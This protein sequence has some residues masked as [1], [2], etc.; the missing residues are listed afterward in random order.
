[1]RS[2][3]FGLLIGFAFFNVSI[4]AQQAA[5]PQQVPVTQAIRDS[6]AVSVLNQI[7]T[8]A[9]GMSAIAA[10]TDYTATGNITYNNDPKLQGNDTLRGLSLNNF[11]LD[12]SLPLGMRSMIISEG[13]TTQ[14]TEDGTITQLHTLAPMFP[15][16]FVLP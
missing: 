10:I 4:W 16:S 14:K 8:V 12:A 5:S 11:R 2:G 3:R 13:R 1:M 6:Q 7:L 9:G 15:A